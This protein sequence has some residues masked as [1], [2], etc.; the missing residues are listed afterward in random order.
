MS[1]QQAKRQMPAQ[2]GGSWIGAVKPCV[3]LA[4]TR[5]AARD[6]KPRHRVGDC[7]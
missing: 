7:W 2:A 1:M 6:M 5:K 4:A 3:N